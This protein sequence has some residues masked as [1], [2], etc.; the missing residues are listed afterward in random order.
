MRGDSPPTPPAPHLR[1]DPA[2]L[3]ATIPNSTVLPPAQ[4]DPYSGL[5]GV[6][7]T[8]FLVTLCFLGT[9]CPVSRGRLT[10]ASLTVGLI[11][12]DAARGGPQH[13]LPYSSPLLIFNRL[14]LFTHLSGLVLSCHYLPTWQWPGSAPA[15]SPAGFL[16]LPPIF[17]GEQRG[18]R[19]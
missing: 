10:L 6:G 17:Q 9:P 2:S 8:S 1:P 15:G 18:M 12:E 7:D 16:L 3:L 13:P 19:G 14:L 5:R 4:N 11:S